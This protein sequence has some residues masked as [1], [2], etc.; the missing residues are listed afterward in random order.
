MGTPSLKLNTYRW[1]LPEKWYQ[2]ARTLGKSPKKSSEI[3]NT[4]PYLKVPMHPGDL[5][6]GVSPVGSQY[7]NFCPVPRFFPRNLQKPETRPIFAMA[8]MSPRGV[9]L[10]GSRSGPMGTKLAH[11][12]FN[13]SRSNFSQRMSLDLRRQ[14]VVPVSSRVGHRNA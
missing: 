1:K 14:G 7:G 13:S 9:P 10:F 3:A 11:V 4:T 6:H 2:V 12:Q 5:I 8:K